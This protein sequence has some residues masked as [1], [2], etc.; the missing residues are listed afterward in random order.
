MR[1]LNLV[2][3]VNCVHSYSTDVD[4]RLCTRITSDRNF[5]W[6]VDLSAAAAG[7]NEDVFYKK[8]PKIFFL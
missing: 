4:I 8:D 1:L 2:R 5:Q 3:Y 6:T 7:W